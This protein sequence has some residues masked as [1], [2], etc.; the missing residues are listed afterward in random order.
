MSQVQSRSSD[1]TSV[2]NMPHY[3]HKLWCAVLGLNQPPSWVIRFDG[4]S[5]GVT[6]SCCGSS[7]SLQPVPKHL[8]LAIGRAGQPGIANSLIALAH[9]RLSRANPDKPMLAKRYPA[10]PKA[11]VGR[12]HNPLVRPGWLSCMARQ[13]NVEVE[14]PPRHGTGQQPGGGRSRPARTTT[15]HREP[16]AY[17]RRTG[18]P[19][20]RCQVAPLIRPVSRVNVIGGVAGVDLGG[21]VTSQQCREGLID[22]GGVGDS[23]PHAPSAAEEF[24]IHRRAQAHAVHAMNMP[25]S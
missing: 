25:L 1:P 21:S 8:L 3:Q 10:E 14:G 9:S 16:A 19:P 6:S 20:P 18:R 22:E 17:S 15:P 12:S 24:G 7:A 2:S 13:G 23:R 5:E 4:F 11:Q